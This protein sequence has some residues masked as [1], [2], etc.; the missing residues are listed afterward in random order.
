MIA[1]GAGL[2]TDRVLIPIGRPS[3]PAFSAE[4]RSPDTCSG[5]P[6]SR[7]S[8][9]PLVRYSVCQR[10]RLAMRVLRSPGHG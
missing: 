1:P 9:A 6:R 7:G 5:A 10:G 2:P 8:E 3:G 4:R